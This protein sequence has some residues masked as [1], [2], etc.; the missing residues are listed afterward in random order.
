M[1]TFKNSSLSCH[2]YL[3]LI[4]LSCTPFIHPLPN[5]KLPTF[6]VNIVNFRVNKSRVQTWLGVN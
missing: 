4:L 6:A 5:Q 3:L 2:P 1:L